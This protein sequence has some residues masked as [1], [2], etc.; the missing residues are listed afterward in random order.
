M[1]RAERET[2]AVV[3]A[4]G[5]SRRLG[6]PK[7]LCTYE[8]QT[9]LER[10]LHCVDSQDLGLKSI[11]LVTGAARTACLELAQR[12]P[13]PVQEIFNPDF[14][15]GLASSISAA[16]RYLAEEDGSARAAVFL[17]CDQIFL[18]PEH[19]AA[20]IKHAYEAEGVRLTASSY[21]ATVGIPAL[22]P[23]SYWGKLAMLGAGSQGAKAILMATSD[24]VRVPFPRGEIDLDTPEEMARYGISF[25][26][27][28]FGDLS[29]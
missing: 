3:L 15:A 23:R 12:S 14:R 8:G 21:E 9:L 29:S 25:D 20:L 22:F 26:R 5:L 18:S 17:H 4:A 16:A 11:Y 2:V 1:R 6:V 27:S 24:L 13:V 10:A 28:R 7:Q 19:I